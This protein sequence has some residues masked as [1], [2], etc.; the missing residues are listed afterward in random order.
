MGVII[1]FIVGGIV[2][3]I[4]MC[5]VS[6]NKRDAVTVVKKFEGAIEHERVAAIKEKKNKDY[7]DGMTRIIML[8][9]NFFS[10][11]LEELQ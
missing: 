5:L 1:A 9:R 11:E 3:I 8:F 4:L 7:I 6:V 2:G 10:K